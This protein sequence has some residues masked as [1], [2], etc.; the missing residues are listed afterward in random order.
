VT[1][2][3]SGN[4][5]QWVLLLLLLLLL[6]LCGWCLSDQLLLAQL[7]KPSSKTF[8]LICNLSA[9]RVMQSEG[10]NGQEW[11]FCRIRNSRKEK[12]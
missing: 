5:F 3:L 12:D 6:P 10:N 8:V 9:H 1:T 7:C 2:G 4:H 11:L